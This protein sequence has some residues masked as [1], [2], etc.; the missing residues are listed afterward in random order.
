MPPGAPT[1][2]RGPAPGQASVPSIASVPRPFSI[3]NR[4]VNFP[5][6][7][8]MWPGGMF[9]PGWCIG[10]WFRCL[11]RR[12]LHHRVYEG[13]PDCTPR[14]RL[15]PEEILIDFTRPYCIKALFCN[16]MFSAVQF[17]ALK[18]FSDG[19]TSTLK[20]WTNVRRGSDWWA[21]IVDASF[22]EQT[23]SAEHSGSPEEG[24]ASDLIVLTPS[25]R[26]RTVQQCPAPVPAEDAN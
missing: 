13:P 8:A 25:R 16:S 18:T 17:K 4:P 12:G 19:T 21:E 7:N 1:S 15:G 5:S 26:T 10:A 11:N 23:P 22:G 2:S 24:G 3:E 20:V 6:P 14:V 9:R